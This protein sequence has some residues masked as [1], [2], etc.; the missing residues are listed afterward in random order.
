MT[1]TPE[2]LGIEWQ[3]MW[4]VAIGQGEDRQER[5][6]DHPFLRIQPRELHMDEDG[7]WHSRKSDSGVW[8]LTLFQPE[9]YIMILSKELHLSFV[10]V[11]EDVAW[12]LVSMFLPSN[13]QAFPDKSS[14]V[15]FLST[16]SW[17]F[18]WD[19]PSGVLF[20]VKI[21]SFQQ[22][23]SLL[24]KQA[25]YDSLQ[26]P[27]GRM[28]SR[29]WQ[30]GWLINANQLRFIG[31]RCFKSPTKCLSLWMHQSWGNNTQGLSYSYILQS[32]DSAALHLGAIPS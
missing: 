31:Q 11:E 6:K 3:D 2:Q 27:K 9:I 21:P 12:W 10:H 13:L 16:S 4:S 7:W 8:I 24:K 25:Y 19:I 17:Y 5:T 20:A 18:S 30:V 26:V 32:C 22:T 1:R 23:M 28:T 14:Q 15:L 29:D